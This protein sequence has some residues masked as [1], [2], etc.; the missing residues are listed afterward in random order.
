MSRENYM[1][2]LT[3]HHE[4]NNPD[5]PAPQC[6]GL[7]EPNPEKKCGTGLESTK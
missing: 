4:A 6:P 5:S 3:L 2:F 1:F 7:V